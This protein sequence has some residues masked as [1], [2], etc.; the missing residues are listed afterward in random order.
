MTT[1]R[2]LSIIAL[3]AACAAACTEEASGPEVLPGLT[4]PPAPANGLQIL[5]PIVRDLAPGTDSEICTWTDVILDRAV[6]VRTMVGHQT[7]PPG[8]HI[9]IYY[10]TQKLPPGTQRV[11]TDTDM[12]TFRFVGGVTGDGVPVTLPGN[13]VDRIPAGAQMVINDHYLNAYDEI[14]DAQSV[15]NLEFADPGGSYI[16]SG[17]LAVLNSAHE[18]PVGDGQTLDI[19]CT[20]DRSLKMWKVFPHAHR[21][22]K[23]MTID[24][25]D[26]GGVSTRL[27]DTVWEEQFTFHAPELNRD[28]ADPLMFSPGDHVKVHCEWNN[29]SGRPLPFGFEMCVGYGRFIDDAGIG[30]IACDNGSWGPF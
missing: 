21:W 26:A 30:N 6:D 8:H 2:S 15:T 16:P 12:A 29:D 5:T 25:V 23:K 24:H 13:L 1:P 3:G 19:D 7:E 11:C 20:I 18:V 17:S 27:F 9:A 14:L 22:A 10:T 28:P 4:V